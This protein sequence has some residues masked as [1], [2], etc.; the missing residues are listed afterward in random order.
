MHINVSEV[1][2]RPVADVFR[3]YAEE[4][5]RNHPRWD[6]HI[7]LEAT[8][9]E[10]MG[11]GTILRRTNTRSGS[12]V[13]GTMEVIE[14]EPNRSIAVLTRDGDVEISGRATFEP[15]GEDRTVLTIDAEMPDMG[16]P[17]EAMT[18]MVRQSIDR[19]KELIEEEG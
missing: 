9:D 16:I 15:R 10:P 8:S 4:H 7:Q 2:D 12:P 11:V 1:I 3:F 18:G 5:V 14:Y 17:Q 13:E 6:P 19:I